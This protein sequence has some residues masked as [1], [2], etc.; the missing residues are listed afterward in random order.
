MKK[1]LLIAALALTATA[2][3][4]QDHCSAK[5]LKG[6]QCTRR[7]KV[8]GYC[9]QHNPAAIRCAGTTQAGNPCKLLPK[10]ESAYCHLHK[11]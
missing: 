10:K 2:A 5:T 3:T 9:N 1:L 6:S 8:N 4:A 11:K 7:A